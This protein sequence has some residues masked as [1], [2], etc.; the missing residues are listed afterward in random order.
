MADNS[1]RFL[2]AYNALDYA[3]R[4]QY[5]FKRSMAFSDVIRRSVVLNSVVRKYEDLL[6]DYGRL[7]N[8]II[9]SGNETEVIAEPHL[10]VVEKMEKIASLVC[11]PPKVLDTVCKK[12]VLCISANDT[13]EKAIM[14]ISR[15]GF[16]NLPVYENGELIGV[17]N[18]QKLVDNLGKVLSNDIS[19]DEYVKNT[20]I[21]EV[22]SLNI[23]DLYYKIENESLTLEKALDIF[24]HNR[25][26]LVILIT[27]KGLRTDKPLG[28]VSVADIM[29]INNILEN[30]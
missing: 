25:K 2:K 29:D 8:A 21:K 28:I 14:T 18:G 24:Y 19:L 9:H 22:I 15:S 27:K 11:T 6:V 1:T 7:R 10:N 20:T 30:Y 17:A 12:D 26:I 13:V 23:G 3:L 4:T 5:N 16:S